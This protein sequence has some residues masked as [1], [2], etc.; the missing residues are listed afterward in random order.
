MYRRGHNFHSASLCAAAG[1]K[2]KQRDGGTAEDLLS[3][4]SSGR[5]I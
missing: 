3:F 2:I 5:I 4:N 1:T